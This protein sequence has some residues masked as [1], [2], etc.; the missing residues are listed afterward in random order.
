MAQHA[1]PAQQACKALQAWQA[2][3]VQGMRQAAVARRT[4][5]SMVGWQRWS[6][7]A[8]TLT[9]GRPLAQHNKQRE[10]APDFHAFGC[11]TVDAK[12]TLGLVIA[13]QIVT[14]PDLPSRRSPIAPAARPPPGHHHR[15]PP[16]PADGPS[17]CRSLA[18]ACPLLHTQPALPAQP[19]PAT[20]QAYEEGRQ[21]VVTVQDRAVP[22]D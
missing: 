5:R 3:Q 1:H 17:L 13:D 20:L 16:P 14:L 9:R 4:W 12:T 7:N 11:N 6:G 15:P 10:S 22:V 18:S 19:W 2:Q 21:M 8:A